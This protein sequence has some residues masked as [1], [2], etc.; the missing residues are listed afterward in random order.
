MVQGTSQGAAALFFIDTGSAVSLVSTGFLKK[1]GL[2]K[3]IRPCNMRLM[4]FS[5]DSIQ[6][7]GEINLSVVIAGT[8]F[9]SRFIA[10]DLLDTEY[11]IGDNFLREERIT[12]DYNRGHLVLPNGSS[13]PFR[14]KPRRVTKQMKVRCNKTTVVPPN[15]VQYIA[16]RLTATSSDYQGLT[17]PFYKTM[18]ETGLLFA[19]AVVHSNRRWVPIKCINATDEPVTIY[20]N[21]MV[22]F[23][24]PLGDH[25]EISGVTVNIIDGCN[26]A[27][28]QTSVEG[29]WRRATENGQ[30]EQQDD[31][32]TE[33][34][35]CERLRLDNLPAKM[36]D[37]ERERLKDIIWKYRKCFSYDEYD[38][39][40]CNMFEADI[41][42]K[43]GV[44]PSWTPPIPTPYK[45]EPEMD[46]QIDQMIRSGVAMPLEEPSDYN[47]PIFLVKKSTPDSWRLV[48]DLRNVNKACTDDRFP[49][50]NLNHV[51]DT[52]G[53]DSIFSC[54]D[55][56]KS[57][58]QIPYTKE[59]RKVTA[60][61][62]KSRAYCFARMIMGH[63]NSS[64]KFTR[65]MN[66]LLATVPIQQLIFFIDDLFLS[67]NRVETQLD[68]LEMLLE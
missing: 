66:K 42:L 41:Q 59:S 62:Y 23:L 9:N 8:T 51:L 65:M 25:E 47:S 11:L 24:Q 38:I 56:S 19:N 60:F 50:P 12:L 54:F 28:V 37:V 46:R 40:C 39:G 29:N 20:R 35:L 10:T 45:L 17:E 31:R 13:A 5:Q 53:S 26:P 21:K 68:R 61:L 55:L 1:L 64:S 48:A 15:S 6:I 58:W 18:A 43:E 7:R 52:I 34:E 22:A 33:K 3:E 27:T 14:D 30:R 49:L 63:K 32:W 36:T 67:S 44:A 2:E 16:G 57:F 4:S